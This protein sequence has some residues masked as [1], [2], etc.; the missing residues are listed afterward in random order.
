MYCMFTLACGCLLM[1]CDVPPAISAPPDGDDKVRASSDG[2]SW[3]WTPQEWT[4]SAKYTDIKDYAD[5]PDEQ[6]LKELS[7]EWQEPE[8]DALGNIC[9]VRGQ[10]RMRDNGRK[11]TQAI[12][13]F[14]GLTVYLAT[15]SGAQPDWSTGMNQ[16]DTLHETAVTSPC[17]KFHV[18]F[19]LRKTKHDRTHMQSFQFGV[20]QAR[21]IVQSKT[22]HNVVWTS[23]SPAIPSTVQVLCIP[24]AR[25]LSS[26]L[27]LVN[28]ASGW[29][30]SNPNGVDLIR[31]VNALQPL[32]KERALA[33]LE[34]YVELTQGSGQFFDQ[35]IV[36]WIISV[37]FEPIRL[38]CRIP[39]PGIAVFLVDRRSVE[40]MKWPLNPMAVYGDVPFMVGRRI[41]LGGQPEAPSAHIRWAR[42]HGVIREDPLVPTGNPLAAA[43]AILGSRRFKVLDNFSR[44]QAT[45][46][47]RLQALAMV[48][49]LLEP[50]DAHAADRDDQW[51]ARLRMAT[52]RGIHWDAKR[53]QFVARD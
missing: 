28:R 17:G 30:F 36:F 41:E 24:V 47:I 9:T 19:D 14:Q 8:L 23:R 7:V 37:L 3:H 53:D 22:R 2:G 11:R 4:Y 32:G 49:G 39:S 43:E 45:S 48:E 46:S 42:L 6:T 15:T 44:S 33:T 5:R 18:C 1:T 26:E 20:A 40:A 31:A 13:W 16:A 25:E 52:E 38:D 27:Q 12:T 34:K 10:I 29:P 51:K 35:D 50:I 21:H